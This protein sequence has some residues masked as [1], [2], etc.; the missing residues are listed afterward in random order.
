VRE[1]VVQERAHDG[2]KMCSTCYEFKQTD[3]ASSCQKIVLYTFT[4]DVI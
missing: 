4:L 2:M 1:A 3:L